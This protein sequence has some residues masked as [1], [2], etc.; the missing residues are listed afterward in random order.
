[1]QELFGAIG[2]KDIFF[3]DDGKKKKKK[4][5]KHSDDDGE[6]SSKKSKKSKKAKKI[7]QEIKSEGELSDD[8]VKKIKKEKKDKERERE[9]VMQKKKLSIIIKDFKLKPSNPSE[10][11]SREKHRDKSK[12]RE[13]KDKERSKDRKKD[14]K[15]KSHK[16]SGSDFSLSDEE[17]YR[18]FYDYHM[19]SRWYSDDYRRDDRVRDWDRDKYQSS[20]SRYG[21]DRNYN[22][23][24]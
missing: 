15:K 14:H 22:R 12:E 11:S 4:K 23:Y 10:S 20:R 19:S 17:T 16:K 2:A 5:R 9:V 21:D 6:G 7:K 24:E 13:K 1:M 8:F 3:R 18:N